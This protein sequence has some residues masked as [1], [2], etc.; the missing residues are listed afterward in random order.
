MN[1]L[2][3]L[4][5]RSLKLNKKRTIVTII[6]IVLATA[7]ITGVTTMLASSGASTIQYA[8][9]HFGDYHLE[10]TNVPS[11]DIERIQNLDNIENTF[12][13]QHAGYG[14]FEY[15]FK[16]MPIQ[17]LNFSDDAFHL[18]GI[19]LIEGSFPKS[20]NEIVISNQIEQLEN[21]KLSIGS[22]LSFS[23]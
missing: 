19:E 8:K 16:E 4:T 6:G 10:I 3:K 7:L 11:N 20:D 5:F 22:T 23:I 1:I 12:L 14:I 18:L 9:Q 15:A 13:T 17:V 2:S 21:I